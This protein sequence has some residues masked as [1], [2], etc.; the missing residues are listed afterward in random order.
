VSRAALL[1]LVA[2]LARATPAGAQAAQGL[3]PALRD[4]GWEQRIGAKLP[5][6]VALRDEAGREVRLADYFGRRPV[7]LAF[8]YY[9]CPMLCTLALNGLVS[10]MGVLSFDP[11][12]EYEV[13]TVSFDP[14]DTPELAAAKKQAYLNRLRRPGAESGWHFLTASG[15]SVARLTQAAGFRYAWDEPTRQFAHPAGIVVATPEGTL[16][17]YLFGIEYAPRDLRYALVEASAG[18]LGSPLDQVVLYCYSYDPATGRYGVVIMRVVRVA[19]AVTV[20]ALGGFIALMLRRER[21]QARGLSL[22]GGSR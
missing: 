22:P 1:A 4:V 15:A 21:A 16:S 20:L 13:V 3:P 2:A 19:G 9:E 11:G 12:R 8:V 17:H 10:A 14:E 5:L 7:V 6:D 18:R